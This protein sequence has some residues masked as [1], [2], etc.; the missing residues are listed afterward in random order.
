MEMTLQVFGLNE[1]VRMSRAYP[2][3]VDGRLKEIFYKAAD[4]AVKACQKITPVAAVASSHDPLPGFLRDSFLIEEE[5]AA[6]SSID[7]HVINDAE[8]ASYV[9][10]GTWKMPARDFM[11]AGFLYGR[12]YIMNQL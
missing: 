7:V 5:S 8:Y 4:R 1:A 3:L 9:C 6:L 2:A 12:E 11:T 10:L